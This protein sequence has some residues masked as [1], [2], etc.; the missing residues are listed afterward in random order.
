MGAQMRVAALVAVFLCF[1]SQN[2]EGYSLPAPG[3]K[4]SA[5]LTTRSQSRRTIS[6]LK[7]SEL[8][9]WGPS[10]GVGEDIN[11]KRA[12]NGLG[13]S[14]FH[15]D[16][17]SHGFGAFSPVKRV[18][19]ALKKRRPEMGA[20]GFYGDTFNGGLGYFDTMKRRPEMDASGF[21]GDTFNGGM[22]Y[23]DTMKRRPEMDAS[24][25][26]GDVF[27]NG[28]GYFD[29]MKRKMA[30]KRRPEMDSSGFH[31][32]TFSNGFGYFDTMKRRA[33]L[34][35]RTGIVSKSESLLQK[36]KSPR[37]HVLL[38]DEVQEVGATGGGIGG[39]LPVSRQRQDDSMFTDEMEDQTSMNGG[40][41]N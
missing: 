34:A 5:S 20:N 4:P 18:S 29:T 12:P 10:W 24:G 36:A 23:F 21:Y 33:A 35:D 3:G 6:G 8:A 26:H 39:R 11:W 19:L 17:F 7:R 31:G 32:D 14:G 37:R 27:S 38:R 41:R 9:D 22:G 30:S 13:R 1:A 15:G 28:F 2:C 40:A 25:F 16:V